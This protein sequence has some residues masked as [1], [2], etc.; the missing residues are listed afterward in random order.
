MAWTSGSAVN[1]VYV[2]QMGT[3]AT[4]PSTDGFKGALFTSTPTPAQSATVANNEYASGSGPWITGSESTA[5]GYT[6][7]GTALTSPVWSQ[8][9]NSQGVNVLALSTATNLVWTITGGT[10]STV[11]VI[12][13]DTTAASTN[14]LYSWNFFGTTSV[15]SGTLTVAWNANG[16]G[17]FTC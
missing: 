11:G 15:S 17:I 12:V 2:L 1:A 10:L 16:I 5:T 7:G 14:I 9:Y 13:Y 3:N 8:N 6:A 4:K